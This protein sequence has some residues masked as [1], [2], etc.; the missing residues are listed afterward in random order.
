MS[1]AIKKQRREKMEN[2]LVVIEE[3]NVLAAFSSPDGLSAV[4]EQVK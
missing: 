3:Q 4:I 2:Q 1:T